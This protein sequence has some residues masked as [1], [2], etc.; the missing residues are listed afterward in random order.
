MADSTTPDGRGSEPLPVPGLPADWD[1]LATDRIVKVVD[2]VKVKSAGPAIGIARA[3]VF[4]VLGAIL[5]VIAMIVFL[6]G[7]VRLLNIII[8]EGVWLVYIILG[9]IFTLLGAFLWSR[10]PKGA[11]S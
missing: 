3:A 1:R 10:R 2:Q 4:G 11:A 7:L 8:P 5:A 6:I 9:A